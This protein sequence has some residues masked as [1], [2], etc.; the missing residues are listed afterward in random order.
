VYVHYPALKPLLKCTP[1]RERVIE[2]ENSQ[3]LCDSRRI[4]AAHLR[5][6]GYSLSTIGR[7][8]NRHHTTVLYLLRSHKELLETSHEYKQLVENCGNRFLDSPSEAS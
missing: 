7:E 4:V 1:N 8:L 6:R 5:E 3:I 2:R